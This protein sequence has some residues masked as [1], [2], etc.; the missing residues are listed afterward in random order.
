MADP[1]TK[2]A[3]IK[4]SMGTYGQNLYLIVMIDNVPGLCDLYALLFLFS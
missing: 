4:Y 3:I 2:F 1:P